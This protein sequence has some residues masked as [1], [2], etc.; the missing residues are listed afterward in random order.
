MKKILL[1]IICFLCFCSCATMTVKSGDYS[2]E[3]ITYED[4]TTAVF[5][6]IIKFKYDGHSYIWFRRYNGYTKG[7]DGGVVLDP[8]IEGTQTENDEN[9]EYD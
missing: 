5:N 4:P 2:V 7:Y 9:I 6:D 3:T 1:L 8:N